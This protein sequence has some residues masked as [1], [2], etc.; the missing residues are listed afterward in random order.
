MPLGRSNLALYGWEM[1]RL[2]PRNF[3]APGAI[4]VPRGNV[5][6]FGAR[7]ERPMSPKV[8]LVPVLEFRHEL[9]GPTDKMVLL[10]YLVRTGTDV[11]YRLSARRPPSCR[12]SLRSASSTTRG[13]AFS[14]VG[15]RLGV[16]IEWSR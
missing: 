15:P 12:R 6:A 7:L 8:T 5:L 16:L 14:L 4:S 13:K 1:R 3:D 2:R 9:T 10:G 11:R